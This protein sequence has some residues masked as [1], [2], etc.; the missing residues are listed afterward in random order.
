MYDVVQMG[1]VVQSCLLFLRVSGIR[2]D[3]AGK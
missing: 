1:V 3:R 2:A